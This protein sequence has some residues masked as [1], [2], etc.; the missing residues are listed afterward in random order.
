MKE[1]KE[2]AIDGGKQEAGKKCQY[3]C[4][5]C[6]SAEI[7]FIDVT[8]SFGQATVE[9]LFYCYRCRMRFGAE[10]EGG[11]LPIKR[12]FLLELYPLHPYDSF[13][14]CD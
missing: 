13:C 10:D 11:Y 8:S 5:H 6:D 12:N 14:S 1:K 3:L 9:L 4:P 2:E 7:G